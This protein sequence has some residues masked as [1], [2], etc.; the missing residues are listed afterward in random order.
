MPRAERKQDLQAEAEIVQFVISRFP[1]QF[2]GY[3][4]IDRFGYRLDGVLTKKHRFGY[5]LP[6]MFYE[7]KNRDYEFGHYPDFIISASKLGEAQ[8]LLVQTGLRSVLLVRFNCGTIASVDFAKHRGKYREG[9][10]TDRVGF[11]NDIETVAIFQWTD[12]RILKLRPAM[13][14]ANSPESA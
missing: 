3:M 10:R 13:G 6:V 14:L 9:G 8:R 7:A 12:F 4:K 11:V 1:D 5:A 2:D